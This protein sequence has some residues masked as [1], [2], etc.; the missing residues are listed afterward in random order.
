L[1]DQGLFC[2]WQVDYDHT[3]IRAAASIF[4]ALTGFVII[5]GMNPASEAILTVGIVAMM[6]AGALPM[7]H[8][9]KRVLAKY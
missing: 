2:Y 3:T 5:P 7:V 6:L 8:F 4:Q 9:I 1:H